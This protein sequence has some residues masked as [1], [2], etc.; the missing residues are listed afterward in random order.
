MAASRPEV[1]GYVLAEDGNYDALEWVRLAP[2]LE[3]RD[4]GPV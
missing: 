3:G 2:A 4:A 1:S